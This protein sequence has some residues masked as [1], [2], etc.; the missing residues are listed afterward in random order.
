MVEK[1]PLSFDDFDG[2]LY[3]VLANG[4]SVVELCFTR[5]ACGGFEAK[6]SSSKVGCS[7]TDIGN[8]SSSSNEE[9]WFCG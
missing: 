5:C 3:N 1:F 9:C 7:S 4:R 6:S 2:F 8:G